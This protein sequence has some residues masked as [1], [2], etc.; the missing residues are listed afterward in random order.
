MILSVISLVA[1]LYGSYIDIKTREIYDTL[2]I[3]LVYLGI[4]IAV[5]ASILLWSYRPLLS[6][7]IGFAVGAAIGLAFYYS[8]QWGGGDAKMLMGLGSIIGI[9]VFSLNA[10]IPDFAILIINIVLFGAIYGVIW[11]FWLALRNWKEFR[12]EFRERRRKSNII[13]IRY[14]F[15][16]LV[17]LFSVIVLVIRPDF[18][19]IMLIYFI[20]LFSVLT[21]YLF[22]IIK[23]VEKSCLLKKIEVKNLTEGDWVLDKVKL[24][25][26]DKYIYTKTGITEKGIKMLQKSK[27]KNVLVKEGIPFVPSFLI[28]YIFLLL[29]GNWFA[30]FHI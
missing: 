10:G 2:S 26:A 17:F 25:N 23:S 22:M 20:F 30:L 16:S 7:L 13:R 11:I 8:G 21:L 5:G 12:I 4:A 9:D 1:L 15:L 18:I 28:A 29:L 14:V 27:I 6:S 3:G 19:I 24:K